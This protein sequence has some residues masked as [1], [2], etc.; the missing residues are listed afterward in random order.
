MNVGT[1]RHEFIRVED[2]TPIERFAL[3]SSVILDGTEY[4]TQQGFP[5]AS[6]EIIMAQLNACEEQ[7]SRAVGRKIV[8]GINP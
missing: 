7:L 5:F 2:G 3:R 1:V 8:K 4:S 6:N